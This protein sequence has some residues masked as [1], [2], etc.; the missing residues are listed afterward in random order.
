M[1]QCTIASPK[2]ALPKLALPKLASPADVFLNSSENNSY[3]TTKINSINSFL[4]KESIS[5]KSESWNK[6]DKTRK[7]KL[8]NHYVDTMMTTHDLSECE[9]EELKQYLVES[10]D[11]RRLQHVKD[12]NCD[13][14]TGK[15]VSIPSLQF[16]NLTKKFTLKRAT[17]RPSTLTLKQPGKNKKSTISIMAS[18]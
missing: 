11:K 4:E 9:G 14:L 2:L 15:I 12:V 6:L 10:L 3:Q 1:E 7:I 18:E 8:L 5:N 16:N 13:K 17:T